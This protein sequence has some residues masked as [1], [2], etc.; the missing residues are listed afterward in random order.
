ML[1]SPTPLPRLLFGAL[2]PFFYE[3]KANT[4]VSNVCAC[5]WLGGCV[6]ANAM[7]VGRATSAE[8]IA[9]AITKGQICSTFYYTCGFA[10]YP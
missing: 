7:L 1:H 10:V 3:S 2:F 5:G 6:H 4:Q 8:H 9:G